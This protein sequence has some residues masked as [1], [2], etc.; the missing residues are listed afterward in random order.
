MFPTSQLDD[1]NETRSLLDQ[2]RALIV[3]SESFKRMTTELF[4]PLSK[5]AYNTATSSKHDNIA[6]PSI[7]DNPKISKILIE[8]YKNGGSMPDEELLDH[9][10]STGR[11]NVTGRGTTGGP[12]KIF[13][14][15]PYRANDSAEV[16][17]VLQPRG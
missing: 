8:G 13:G 10:F 3:S 16:G 1:K 9:M 7:L 11:E 6:T 17:Q 12:P 2:Y 14:R 5:N 4:Y 15:A